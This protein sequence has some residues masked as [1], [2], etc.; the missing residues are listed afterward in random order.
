MAR[1]R[2]FYRCTFIFTGYII[3]ILLTAYE[4]FQDIEPLMRLPVNTSLLNTHMSP[5]I[6]PILH[7]SWKSNRLPSV[8][9]A[10]VYY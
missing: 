10:L 9:Y 6:P 3:I 7:Q 1:F 5:T 2:S 4:A 8:R